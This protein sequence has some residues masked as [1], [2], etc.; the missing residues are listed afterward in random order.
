MAITEDI[1]Q[2]VE[3]FVLSQ[4]NCPCG[5]PGQWTR[6]AHLDMSDPSQQCPSIWSLI[7]TPVRGCGRSGRRACDSVTFPSTGQ[8]Y[9]HVCGR[10][11]A[12]QS[13]R[14]NAFNPGV[15][16]QPSV[17]NLLPVWKVVILMVSPSLMVLKAHVSTSGHLL[18]HC[19]R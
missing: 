13:G 16:I 1:F 14:P 9:S 2:Q 8:S 19:W 11:T 3:S 15:L 7:T 12:Y 17:L 18:Q 10:V 6:I 4:Y 5:G